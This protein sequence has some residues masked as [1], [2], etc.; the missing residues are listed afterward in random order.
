MTSLYFEEAEVG[1]LRV[2]GPDLVSRDEIIEFAKKY[3]P[4]PFHTNEEA[5]ARSVF[6]GLTASA[7]HTFAIVIWLLS[8]TQ[9]FSLLLAGPAGDELRLPI[10][11][12]EAM[13]LVLKP[14]VK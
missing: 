4:Q 2:A 14:P 1:K 9:P 12:V 11:V 7:A 5:A 3:D 13:N 6:E 8:R 10:S